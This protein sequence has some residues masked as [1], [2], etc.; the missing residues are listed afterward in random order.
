MCWN[1][2]QADCEA[3]KWLLQTQSSLMGGEWGGQ[4]AERHRL[5]GLLGPGRQH[6]PGITGSGR[7][8]G[9]LEAKALQCY[10]ALVALPWGKLGPVLPGLQFY[11]ESGFWN[12][13]F[14]L[15]FNTLY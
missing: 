7:G 14:F 1:K 12:T 15:T 5:K 9:E 6:S 8:C 3:G 2:A 11:Q 10:T 4:G 13:G